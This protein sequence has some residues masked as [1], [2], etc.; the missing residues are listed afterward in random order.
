[1]IE[2]ALAN[3]VDFD[4]KRK[5]N[6]NEGNSA[7]EEL[8]AE[9][10]RL[11]AVKKRM[12]YRGYGGDNINAFSAFFEENAPF[13]DKIAECLSHLESVH[14]A[15]VESYSFEDLRKLVEIKKHIENWLHMSFEKYFAAFSDFLIPIHFGLL[16]VKNFIAGILARSNVS[17]S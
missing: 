16:L 2:Y 14:I 4:V 12:I 13:I 5:N 11:E 6:A 7:V 15:E 10:R 3:A 17:T 1:M 9:K 8:E